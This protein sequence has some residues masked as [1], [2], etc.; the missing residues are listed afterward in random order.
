MK[1]LIKLLNGAE[2]GTQF[3]FIT[4]VETRQPV[5]H[6]VKGIGKEGR[7]KVIFTETQPAGTGVLFATCRYP[8]ETIKI[9]GR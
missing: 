8:S 9:L 2:T 6:T 5:I 3:Q 1:T 7:R 4:S